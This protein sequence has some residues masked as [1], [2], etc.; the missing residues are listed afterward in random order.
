[1]TSVALTDTQTS[2]P[3]SQAERRRAAPGVTSASTG[4]GRVDL[5]PHDVAV[6]GERGDRAR[7]RRCAG[8]RS[9]ARCTTPPPTGEKAANAGP[10]SRSAATDESLA[11][12]ST[13]PVRRPSPRTRLSPTSAATCCGARMGGHVG[14]GRPSAR[15]ARR[16][17]R[18]ACRPAPSRPARVGHDDAD[19]R[20]RVQVLA[21]LGPQRHRAGASRAAVG[22]SSSSMPGSRR[23]RAGD[24]HPLRLTAGQLA[25]ACGRRARRRRAAR[26]SRRASRG[27]RDGRTPRARGP[28]ATLSSA[29]GGGTAGGPGTPAHAALVA[30]VRCMPG[31]DQV[32]PPSSIWPVVDRR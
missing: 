19:A 7:A 9:G 23:Q 12:P 32:S 5:Q 3:G 15:P 11:E 8:C 30:P 24:R 18:P 6:R 10:L 27:L 21:Q 28:N 20:E 17:A 26:A 31:L 1:M 14:R 2:L 25:R 13:T 16:R 29:S 4:G 22:S